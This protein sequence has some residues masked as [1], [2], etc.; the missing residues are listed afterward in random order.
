MTLEERKNFDWRSP[1]VTAPNEDI[2]IKPYDAIN[3][4]F[5]FKPYLHDI[6][7]S[8]VQSLREHNLSFGSRILFKY[9][10]T[11]ERIEIGQVQRI[12]KNE[13]KIIV[14]DNNTQMYCFPDN[15]LEFD[16]SNVILNIPYR[17][18]DF[19]KCNSML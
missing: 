10:Y 18:L 4:Y 5:K 7:K 9:A 3:R 17:E 14:N 6:F 12:I 8:E 19:Y 2:F 15:E 13:Q 16:G 1:K 11:I